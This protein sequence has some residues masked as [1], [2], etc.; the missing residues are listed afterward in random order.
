MEIR[1][2]GR[3][4]IGT[5]VRGGMNV[6]ERIGERSKEREG[7]GKEGEGDRDRDREGGE[8]KFEG[9]VGVCA[10]GPA[11]LIVE[12]SNVVASLAGT[13]LG[14]RVGLHTEVFAVG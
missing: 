11:S 4:D 10:S 14:G 6:G 9:C 8:R 1:E 12:A 5:L 3:P 13:R 7:E 2:G